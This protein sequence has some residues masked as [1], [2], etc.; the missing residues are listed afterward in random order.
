MDPKRW[1]RID[2]LLSAA[3]EHESEERAS[4]LVQACEG[5]EELRKQVERLLRTHQDA[6]SFLE[7][8]PSDAASAIAAQTSSEPD[9]NLLS[10]TRPA[11]VGRGLALGR[12]IVLNKLGG[13]GMGVVYAASSG[14]AASR[15]TSEKP[16]RPSEI[17]GTFLQAGRGLA[18]TTTTTRK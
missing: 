7:T 2:V 15:S 13:G 4:F 18:H 16:R 11:E 8:L 6:G 9:R 5:D 1:Q 3:S 17:V 10:Q 14:A 12:Y